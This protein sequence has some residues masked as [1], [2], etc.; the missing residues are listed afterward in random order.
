MHQSQ[1]SDVSSGGE[2]MTEK[3]NVE[4]TSMIFKNRNC[5]YPINGVTDNNEYAL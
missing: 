4:T 2:E 5:P 3:A 1:F